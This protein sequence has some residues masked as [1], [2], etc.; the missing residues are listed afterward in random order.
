MSKKQQ[1]F[2]KLYEAQKKYEAI[3]PKW[4]L[5][6]P[7]FYNP[8][9][10]PLSVDELL[11]I[12]AHSE[13]VINEQVAEWYNSTLKPAWQEP[14]S[15]STI[16]QNNNFIIIGELSSRKRQYLRAQGTDQNSGNGLYLTNEEYSAYLTERHRRY[17][18]NLKNF[19]TQWEEAVKVATL[20]A[21]VVGGVTGIA[22]LASLAAPTT[23]GALAGQ[24]GLLSGVSTINPIAGVSLIEA[25][26]TTVG[27]TVI[28]QII[29]QG[30]T[31][32]DNLLNNEINKQINNLIGDET[33]KTQTVSAPVKQIQSKASE[34]DY[35]NPLLYGILAAAAVLFLGVA[36]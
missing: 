33:P 34:P 2:E 31:Q 12:V 32:V 21:V 22:S 16:Q 13:N 9:R 20:A 15:G 28:D 29:N 7:V 17:N 19:S 6:V 4:F 14:I 5:R 30:K 10:E 8:D 18:E 23:T 24:S 25:T 3:D 1:F 11:W 26:S 36:I 35:K 27:A